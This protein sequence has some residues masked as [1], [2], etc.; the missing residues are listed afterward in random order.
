MPTTSSTPGAPLAPTSGLSAASLALLL[1]GLTRLLTDE[2]ETASYFL[3]LRPLY[4]IYLHPLRRYPGPKLWA[5]SSLPWG[6]SFLS[7]YW[8]H[9]AL[10]L[11]TKYGHVVR[12]G[13][14]ELSF[15]VPE[16]WEDVC[17][18]SKHRKENPKAPWYLNP[19]TKEIVSAPLEEHTRMRRLLGIGFTNTAMLEQ[20]PLIKSHVDLFIQRLHEINSGGKAAVDMFEWF[21]YCTFDI[22]GDL[23]FGEPF[24][25]LRDSM[26]HPWIAWVFANIKL[27]HTLVLC[28]R[29]PFFFL[30]LP[31]RQ[32]LALVKGA[33]YF[34]K[35]MKAVI[36]RRLARDAERPDLLQIMK[37]PRGSSFMTQ[38]EI[39]SN[40]S[41]LTMAGSETTS[42]S[43]AVAVYMICLYPE[44]K[45]KIMDELAAAFNSES[46]IDMRSAG[47][48]T[49]LMAVI[50]ESM[51]YHPPG[52]NALWR[53]TPS[54]GNEIL[55][56]WLPAKTILGIPHRVMYRREHN[57]KRANEFI[58]ER[59]LAYAEMRYIL[60]RLIWNFDFE[61]AEQSR[62]WADGLRAWLIWEKRPLYVHLEPRRLK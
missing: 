11:H 21:A 1:A 24:G 60:A 3:L 45:A 12:I 26:L 6:F 23:S 61:L 33:G 35:T 55:G 18:R 31:I 46:E 39:H 41:F 36:D 44:T 43:M 40:A 49:Y 56:N 17:G 38:E 27:A 47:K 9:R 58:P 52:P 7:G 32:T 22:I 53:I 62:N 59:C 20:E 25:C 29:I 37:T 10:Q 14:N 42:N 28:N 34:E 13:P 57:F 2:V 8:H 51:R 50:Q 16:A 30:F 4:N 54:G 19:K 48:L 5:A 15:D